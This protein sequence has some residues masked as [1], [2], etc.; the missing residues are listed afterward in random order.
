LRHP[1][2]VICGRRAVSLNQ[3]SLTQ[4]LPGHIAIILREC[5]G[6]T[7]SAPSLLAQNFEEEA[8]G[9]TLFGEVVEFALAPSSDASP[10]AY[11]ARLPEEVCCYLHRV[12]AGH[13][14]V[15]IM[16]LAINSI[17]LC[18]HMLMIGEIVDGVQRVF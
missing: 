18:D 17:G 5:G 6:R 2:P 8:D 14:L 15:P 12:I 1:E 3:G 9:L 11:Q 4:T 10:S 7:I 13:V 16:P